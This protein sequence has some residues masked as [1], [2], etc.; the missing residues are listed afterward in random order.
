MPT[1]WLAWHAPYDDPTSPL[2]RRLAAVTAGVTSWLDAA[3][4]GPLQAISCCAGQGRDLTDALRRHPR[5]PDVRALLVEADE[6]NGAVAAERAE[7]A[8]LSQVTVRVADASATDV[9]AGAVPADLVLVCGVFGNISDDDIAHTVAC[10]PSLCAPGATVVWT[11]HR[12]PPD[13]TPD[14]RRW[15][16]A[17][18]FEELSFTAP[19][20]DVFAVGVARLSGAPLPFEPGVRLFE[21]V[22]DGHRPA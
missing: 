5:A 9:Y 19:A 21:F 7:A 16:V 8:G 12:R 15:L 4:P 17:A 14:I 11:R 20:E 6:R 18:G 3:R 2:S 13:R 22:G 1:D 10:L